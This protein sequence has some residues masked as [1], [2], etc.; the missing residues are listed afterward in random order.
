MQGK[1]LIGWIIGL[2]IMICVSKNI[3]KNWKLRK[4]LFFA[5]IWMSVIKKLILPVLRA[6]KKPQVLLPKKENLSQKDTLI[7]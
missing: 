3:F 2:K 7:I 5:E 6:I 1:N 4:L